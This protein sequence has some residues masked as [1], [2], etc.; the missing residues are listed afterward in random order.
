MSTEEMDLIERVEQLEE[1]NKKL[2]KKVKQ[3]ETQSDGADSIGRRNLMKGMVGGGAGAALSGSAVLK[4]IG[5]GSADSGAD[6]MG[7]H[8]DPIDPITNVTDYLNRSNHPPDPPSGYLTEYFIDGEKVAVDA[9]GN[10]TRISGISIQQMREFTD[11]VGRVE[12]EN[13]NIATKPIPVPDG[14]ALQV[15][16][17]G[18]RDHTGST[19][20]GLNCVLTDETLTVQSSESTA[21]NHDTGSVAQALNSSGS[22]KWYHLG[23]ENATG[24]DYLASNNEW[25]TAGFGYRVVG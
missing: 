2:K 8:S 4:F 7:T 9:N 11:D 10:Y 6:N 16:T 20:S 1:E 13:G 24:S 22:V 3:M 15:Y 5:S 19:P 14:K 12:L 23:V 21:Y 18:C 17:W 25:V